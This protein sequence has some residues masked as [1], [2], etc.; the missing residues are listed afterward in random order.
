MSQIDRAIFKARAES[1]LLTLIAN[2]KKRFPYVHL[3]SLLGYLQP[4]NAASA[5]VM[6][7]AHEFGM[8]GAKLWDEFQSFVSR[9]D[10]PIAASYN[11]NVAPN[12]L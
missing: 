4:Q 2:L 11:R 1:Y 9:L 8:P 3:F 12:L 10:P 5:T 7:L 6:E